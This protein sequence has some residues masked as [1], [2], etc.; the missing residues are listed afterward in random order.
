[1]IR[2]RVIAIATA[3]VAGMAVAA[4]AGAATTCVSTAAGI[5]S[6]L[7][8]AQS[9]NQNDAIRIVAGSYALSS[10]L[11]F[12][13][14]EAHALSI[15]GGWNSGCSAFTGAST[16]LNGQNL[17]G[18]LN[19]ANSNGDIHVEHLTFASGNVATAF[20]AP[21]LLTSNSGSVYAD[22]DIFIGNH[23]TAGIGALDA[24]SSSGSVF[25]RNN[26]VIGN[27]GA[28]MGGAFVSQSAGEGYVSGNTI[29]A[30]ATDTVQTAGGL[31][32][33]GTGHFSVSNNIIW[34]NAGSTGYDFNATTAHSRYANDIGVLGGGTSPDKV[35]AEQYVDPQFAPC[36]GVFCFS[37]ELAP[38]SPLADAGTDTPAGG[39]LAV[40]LAGKPRVLGPHVDIG[41]YENEVIFVDG[42]D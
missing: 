10:G 24:Y 3:V 35:V 26:L 41:A 31:A 30:N 19:V 25:V 42:F 1:M 39:L 7:T 6:A 33:G 20:G 5:Q 2:V 22:L 23:A 12:N 18:L 11:V 17:V 28:L 4:P 29:V 8:V 9:N 13:A 14:T 40:D 38:Y 21:V 32:I 27:H 37:F 36:G 16:T 15:G 34:N